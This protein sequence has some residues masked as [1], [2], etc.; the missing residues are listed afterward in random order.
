[1]QRPLI[2]LKSPR[3]AARCMTKN[4]VGHP[5]PPAMSTNVSTMPHRNLVAPRLSFRRAPEIKRDLKRPS[6]CITRRSPRVR[7]KSCSQNVRARGRKSRILCT[8]MLTDAKIKVKCSVKLKSIVRNQISK[9][10]LY[11][12]RTSHPICSSI[13]LKMISKEALLS[14]NWRWVRRSARFRLFTL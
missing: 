3:K 7:R 9:R 1:M 6:R 14:S 4:S 11:K 10:N 2:P 13:V 12:R 8:R 5:N